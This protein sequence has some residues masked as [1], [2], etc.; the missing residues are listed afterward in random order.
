MTEAERQAAYRLENILMPYFRR[1]RLKMFPEDQRPKRFVHY[2]SAEVA[3]K[4][5]KTKRLWMR[6]STCMVDYS[7]VTHGYNFLLSFFSK[8]E[9]RDSF[10][11]ALEPG[12]AGIAH[13]VIRLIDGW[14]PDIRL[15]TYIACFSAHEDQEDFH[16]RLSMW[17]A[18]GETKTTRVAVVVNLPKESPIATAMNIFFSPVAYLSEQEVHDQ[19]V[20]VISNIRKECEFLSS[21]GRQVLLSWLFAMLNAA[22]TCL[23]HPGFFEEREW[24]VVYSPNRARSALIEPSI[25]I[26]AGVPQ[27][28]HKLP[29]DKAVS[30][31]LAELDLSTVFDRLIIGPTPYPWAVGGAFIE[32]LNAAGVADAKNRIW[33]STIPIRG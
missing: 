11:A 32:A 4:I 33:A 21:I 3:L 24:R 2:T 27:I 16:G 23:K 20:Q 9:N 15:N 29:F 6:N 8:Q 31:A 1:E 18:F 12:D 14:L 10:V 19:L 17:R 26:V 7:E 13:E 25:E 5:I 22:V 28:V 30:P